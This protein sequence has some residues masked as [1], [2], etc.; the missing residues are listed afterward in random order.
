MYNSFSQFEKNIGYKFT[1]IKLLAEALCHKSY[2]NE[3]KDGIKSYERL[4]FL[5][6]SILG[7]IVSNYIFDNYPRF[8]EGDLT[9]LRASV[10]C[11]TALSDV[12]R[13]LDAGRY[14]LLSKGED[15]TGGR[16]KDAMLCDVFEAVVAAIYLDG[17]MD[18]AKAFVL[19]NLTEVIDSHAAD[20][21]V[22]NNYKSSLQEYVQHNGGC[23]EYRL[24]SEDGPEHCR[25]YTFGVYVNG[26]CVAEGSDTSKKKA[27]QAAAKIAAKK[28]CK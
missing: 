28:Y 24:H 5:G 3:S 9:K 8:P 25:E 27:L 10:V 13:K 12:S 20:A 21:D 18:S 17:G 14:V 1:D 19:D 23:V 6:D 11:E 2:I 16:D 26:E 22:I 15:M 7:V 4:E